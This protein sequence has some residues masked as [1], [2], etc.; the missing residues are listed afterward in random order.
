MTL[1]L[2][3]TAAFVWHQGSLSRNK[4]WEHLRKNT[5]SLGLSHKNG[6]SIFLF[7]FHFIPQQTWSTPLCRSMTA[8]GCHTHI[9]TPNS[10]DSALAARWGNPNRCPA[11][12]PVQQQLVS[13]QSSM[14]APPPRLPNQNEPLRGNVAHFSLKFETQHR[15]TCAFLQ[16]KSCAV[17]DRASQKVRVS[18]G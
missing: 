10:G 11:V 1:K 9:H 5:K 4:C 17:K 7:L 3:I 14:R 13:A 15:R 8:P 2:L 16:K 12:S 6:K 18:Q